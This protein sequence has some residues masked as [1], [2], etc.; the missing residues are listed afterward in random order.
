MR[1]KIGYRLV[2]VKEDNFMC[3]GSIDGRDWEEYKEK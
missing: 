3:D 1:I 2:W